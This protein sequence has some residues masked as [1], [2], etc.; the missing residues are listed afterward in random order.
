MDTR[1]AVME[2]MKPTRLVVVI[3]VRY[4]G[5]CNIEKNIKTQLK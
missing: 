1:I 5:V 4:D 2:V 3:K